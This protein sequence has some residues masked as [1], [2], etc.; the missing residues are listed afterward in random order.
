MQEN[1]VFKSYSHSKYQNN[2][3]IANDSLISYS[4]DSVNSMMYCESV[5]STLLLVMCMQITNYT[6]YAYIDMRIAEI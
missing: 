1:L 6:V 3:A 2:C 4:C 5:L